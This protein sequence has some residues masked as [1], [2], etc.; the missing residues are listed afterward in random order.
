MA[1]IY[2]FAQLDSP[3]EHKVAVPTLLAEYVKVTL[4]EG[5]K[6][7][8]V[9]EL[10]VISEL[11]M[12]SVRNDKM[13]RISNRTVSDKAMQTKNRVIPMKSI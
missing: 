1:L 2:N 11:Q 12:P 13:K 8:V 10:A 4:C 7:F 6:E 9:V 3:F 5:P